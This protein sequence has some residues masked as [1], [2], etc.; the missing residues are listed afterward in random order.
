LRVVSGFAGFFGEEDELGDFFGFGEG[1]G[2]EDA[3]GGLFV[4]PFGSDEEIGGGGEDFLAA[5]AEAL[6]NGAEAQA[7][8]GVEMGGD[9]VKGVERRFGGIGF[10][11]RSREGARGSGRGGSG[12]MGKVGA[13]VREV[14][15]G[16]DVGE[17]NGAGN[18]E[19]SARGRSAGGFEVLRF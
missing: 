4:A 1:D 9:C 14:E 19:G 6:A 8:G 10:E 13:G 12:G 16:D 18:V 7:R 5:D 11:P 15:G 2:G 3:A 17:G